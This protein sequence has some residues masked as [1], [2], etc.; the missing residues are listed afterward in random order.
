MKLQTIFIWVLRLL[1]AGILLQTL[2]FKFS[3]HP[4]SVAIFTALELE[5]YGRISIGVL[6]LVAALLILVPRTTGLG[7]FL[8]VGL[9]SG[10][11]FF[12]LTKLGIVVD[13]DAILF[14]Y[15]LITL[16]AS[17]LLTWIFR[18]QLFE[19]LQRIRGLILKDN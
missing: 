16:L 7:A 6:E 2:F 18:A 10:A 12:H 19:I 5:P 1:A 15:A 4:Q 13:G 17:M 9:M 14:I 8:A 3:A 11:V